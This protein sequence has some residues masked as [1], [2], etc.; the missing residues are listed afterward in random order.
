MFIVLLFA[1]LNLSVGFAAAVLMGY[2]PQPW[3]ALFLPSD[4]DNVIQIDAIDSE[5]EPAAEKTEAT[6]PPAEPES[7]AVNQPFP[8]MN[9]PEDL[10]SEP[11]PAA[12]EEPAVEE[13]VEPVAEEAPETPV[14][15]SPLEADDDNELAE[16]LAGRKDETKS[17]LAEEPADEEAPQIA[18]ANDIESMFAATQDSSNEA[19]A[20]EEAST[21][22]DAQPEEDL[23]DKP[24]SQDDIAALFNS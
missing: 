10:P 18:S 24:I 1:V 15:E 20:S 3:Y 12:E 16:F 22:E 7:T 6:T 14:S 17:T 23:D 21:Q 9:E 8:E 19:E 4:G 2:G 11:E 5:E 13:P